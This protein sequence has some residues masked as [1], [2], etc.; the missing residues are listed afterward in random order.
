MSQEYL[1][2]G[3]SN[4]NMIGLLEMSLY[5]SRDAA[6]NF[7]DEVKAFMSMLGFRVGRYNVCTLLHS[8]RNLKTMILGDDFTSSGQETD[9]L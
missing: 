2:E 6:S 7:Q 1:E 4:E 3:E 9:L 5:G 8:E